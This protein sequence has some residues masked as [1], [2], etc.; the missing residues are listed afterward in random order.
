MFQQAWI[1]PFGATCCSTIFSIEFPD[2][3]PS[4][5]VEK[6]RSFFLMLMQIPFWAVI[7]WV[8]HSES[9]LI[10]AWWK[11]WTLVTN[12][13]AVKS[14]LLFVKAESE[15][16]QAIVTIEMTQWS[17]IQSHPPQLTQL[18]PLRG[19]PKLLWLWPWCN[20]SHCVCESYRVN[21]GRYVSCSYFE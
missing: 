5:D 16:V 4:L 1:Q 11:V 9:Q 12:N 10:N 20:L 14:S 17:T 2:W 18:S 6:V 21:K 13:K 19:R 3:L 7:Q 8:S 15:S